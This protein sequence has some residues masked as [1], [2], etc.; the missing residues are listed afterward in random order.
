MLVASSSLEGEIIYTL[1][2][3]SITLS[4]RLIF[5]IVLYN[6]RRMTLL[7]GPPSSGKTTLL[8]ALAGKLDKDL[9]VRKLNIRC[10]YFSLA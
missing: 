10:I 8:L 1:S 7:L 3:L 2:C 5:H 4:K 6:S 9:K